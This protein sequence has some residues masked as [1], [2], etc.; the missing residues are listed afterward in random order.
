MIMPVNNNSNLG[1][2]SLEEMINT[3]INEY[4]KLQEDPND[5]VQR[6]FDIAEQAYRLNDKRTLLW[7]LE[8]LYDSVLN[9]DK[10]KREKILGIILEEGKMTKF[11]NYLYCPLKIVYRRRIAYKDHFLYLLY[12][13]S[14]YVSEKEDTSKKGI[15][16]L[17]LYD[18]L[19]NV[20]NLRLDDIKNFTKSIAGR[21]IIKILKI[22]SQKEHKNEEEEYIKEIISLDLKRIH[23]LLSKNLYLG[24]MMKK[25][26][27]DKDFNLCEYMQKIENSGT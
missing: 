12:R 25:N 14:K 24:K 10:H 1:E 23:E 4:N 5:F 26:I 9:L 19:K 18:F 6:I 8:I 7:V 27:K 13:M 21:M 16:K 20:E 3:F 17:I 11:I 15:F 22:L 2:K